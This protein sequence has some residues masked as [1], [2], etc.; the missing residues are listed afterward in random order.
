MAPRDR[1]D[2]ENQALDFGLTTQAHYEDVLAQAAETRVAKVRAYGE[3]RYYNDDAESSAWLSYSDVY[4]K[5]IRLRQQT[6]ELAR[7]IRDGDPSY[8]H[9]AEELRETYMDLLNYAAQG[10]QDMDRII[11]GEAS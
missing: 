3:D 8:D 2:R 1:T 4:R 10:S 5:T 7:A 6:R 11:G 9:L